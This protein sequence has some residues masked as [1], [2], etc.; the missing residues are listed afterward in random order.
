MSFLNFVYKQWSP[1]PYPTTSFEGQTIIVTG[2]NVGLGL[3]AARHVARRGASKVI[4]AVRSIAKGEEAARSVH[5]SI[6]RQGVCEVWQV[7]MGNFDSIKEFVKRVEG[8]ERLDVV[9]E[10]AG[11]AKLVYEWNEVEKLESTIAVNVVGTFLMALELL[12]ILRRKGKEHNVTPRLVVTTSEVHSRSKMAERHEDSIF[13]ALKENN[14]I[15][16]AN[17]YA[18]SKLLEVFM[19]RSLAEHMKLGSHADEPI[20][21]NCVNPGLC[22]SSLTREATGFRGLMFGIMKLVL[23]RSTE[24]GSRTLVASAAAGPESTGQYMSECVVKPPSEFVRS[25]EGSKTQERVFKELVDI[26]EKIQPGISKNI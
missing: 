25:E 3:E 6:G 23:A 9:I 22:H 14:P 21:L 15:Y 18:T 17:R 13:E 2:S 1:L 19:V 24:V 26:L 20:I 4:L 10:N 12:P 8:L 11:I 7:D 5:Q 16:M